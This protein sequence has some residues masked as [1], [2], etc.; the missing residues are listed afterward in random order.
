MLSFTVLVIGSYS[1]YQDSTKSL[2]LI[3]LFFLTICNENKKIEH[4][5]YIQACTSIVQLSP[6]GGIS[7]QGKIDLW[8]ISLSCVHPHVFISW[9]HY[10]ASLWHHFFV[11]GC[12]SHFKYV[13]GV[14][15]SH[16]L[17]QFLIMRQHRDGHFL[18]KQ[19]WQDRSDCCEPCWELL[20]LWFNHR[21]VPHFSSIF[22]AGQQPF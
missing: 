13:G 21:A 9:S 19:S 17:G 3:F 8:S 1:V 20:G 10:T 4:S 16:V 12:A 7:L 14:P 2:V 6:F 11:L 15:F 5:Q 22:G 18:C